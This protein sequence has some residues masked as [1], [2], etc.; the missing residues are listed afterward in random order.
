MFIYLFSGWK[1]LCLDIYLLF[2]VGLKVCHSLHISCQPA[3]C[4]FSKMRF[5]WILELCILITRV[6][7][8]ASLL[9]CRKLSF[10][11]KKKY[12]NSQQTVL[13]PVPPQTHWRV[14]GFSVNNSDGT[15]LTSYKTFSGSL[16]SGPSS[17]PSCGHGP[18]NFV[19]SGQTYR[20]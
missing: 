3:H 10:L 19:G 16:Q 5:Y 14:V 17:H 12:W 9:A 20:E 2:L 18:C 15:S 7:K 11:I 1:N 4:L 6:G 8:T 13:S